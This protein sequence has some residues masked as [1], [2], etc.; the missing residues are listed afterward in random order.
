MDLVFTR[1]PGECYSRRLRSLFLRLCDVFRAV[2]N[3]LCVDSARALWA[4]FG[5]ILKSPLVHFI[6]VYCSVESENKTGN[7]RETTT[8]R[9]GFQVPFFD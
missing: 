1:M 9:H 4:S 7:V 8:S 3:F 6:P 2:I 5:F